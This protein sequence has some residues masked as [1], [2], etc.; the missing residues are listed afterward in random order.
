MDGFMKINLG[1][2]SLAFIS[3]L[4][5]GSFATEKSEAGNGHGQFSARA[6]AFVLK[7][8]AGGEHRGAEI[9]GKYGMLIM[10]TVPNLAQYE[11]S[12]LWDKY[13]EKHPWPAHNAPQRVL[14]EDL[15]QQT[16]FK[17][18]VRGLMKQA[19]KPDEKLLVVVD[20]N[21]DVRRGFGIMNNET[22]ILLVDS[23]G[24]IVHNECDD[25]EPGHESATRLMR[26][27]KQLAE[28]QGAKVLASAQMT[29]K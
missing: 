4:S 17:E 15:S 16:S 29:S 23:D 20:E 3:S 7:D 11:K 26:Q 6:P 21:G 10:I 27:V 18:K 9:F 2:A 8:P 12:K 5:F 28:Q 24:R 13:L 1:L 14:L 22:V 25:V 19:Y